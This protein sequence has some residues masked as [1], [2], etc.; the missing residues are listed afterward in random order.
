[1]V[2]YHVCWMMCWFSR[3]NNIQGINT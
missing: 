2:F 1:M 3:S